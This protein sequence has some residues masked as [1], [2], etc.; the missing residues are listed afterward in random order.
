MRIVT[1]SGRRHNVRIVS[2]RTLGVAAS[3]LACLCA[4]LAARSAQQPA[5][6]ISTTEDTL[7][8]YYLG[9]PIG[10]E[11]YSLKAAPSGMQLDADF[12]YVD[13]GRRTHIQGTLQ[14]GEGYTPRYLQV[15]RLTDTSR[16]VETQVDI[17]GQRATVLRA[18]KSLLVELPKVAFAISPYTPVSQHLAMLRYWMA[19]GSPARIAVVPG[20]PT[21]LVGIERR[22]ADTLSQGAQ[23]LVLTRYAIDGVVWGIEYVWLD[24]TGRLAAFTTAGGGGLS[25]EAIRK[26]LDPLYPKLMEVAAHAAMDDLAAISRSVRPIAEGTVALIGATLVDG[27]GRVAVPNAT[28]VVVNGLVAAA[29][30]SAGTPVPT[31]A[32]RIDVRGKTIVPGLWDMHTHLNQLEWAPVYM[33][34]GV[35]TVRD[36]GNEISFILALRGAVDSGRALGPRMLLA[37]LVDGGGPNAFG[38]VNATTPEE[39]RELVRHY[40]KLGFQQMKLYSL[41][42]PDVVAAICREAHALGMTV[43]GHV[44]TALTLLAAVDSGMDQIAHLPVRGDPQSDSVRR[45][46]AELKRHGTV[47]DPTASWGELLGHSTAEPVTNLQPVLH[48]LPPVLAQRIA[49]MGAPNVDTATAHARLARTLAIIRALHEAGISIVPGTDE[50]VPGFSLYRE[51]E[52]YVKAGMTPMEAIRSATAMSARAMQLDQQVGTLEAG[53]LADLLVL[54]ANPL[55]DISNIRRVRLVMKGGS[56]YDSAALW[57]AAGFRP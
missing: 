4:P 57:R 25:L 12:D 17:Y 16:T 24:D 15:V 11:R 31:G 28:V 54:D 39:G 9:Y 29:G 51:L 42:R 13:R 34:A 45:V 32:R 1:L 36:M 47:I 21:N 10:W 8:L 44:P 53:K 3:T 40:H 19:Q 46:I 33:A 50:G 48:L 30:P 14:L 43:T 52:L 22:G 7:R 55:E 37:G 27:T 6:A 5:P 38:A 41:L 2:R 23:R 35:T 26:D 49:A 56:L 18:G 20:G